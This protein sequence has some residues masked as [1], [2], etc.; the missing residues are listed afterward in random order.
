MWICFNKKR[1]F[2][3]VNIFWTL[4]PLY[5]IIQELCIKKEKKI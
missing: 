1:P 4:M 5:V 3:Y 2:M